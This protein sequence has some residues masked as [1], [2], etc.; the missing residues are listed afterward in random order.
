MRIK[1]VSFIGSKQ[2]GYEC[3]EK[4]YMLDKESLG[5]VITI[6]D[7]GDRRSYFNDIKQ[8]CKKLSIPCFVAENRDHFKGLIKELKPELGFVVG[9]YWLIDKETIDN[10]PNGF[11]GIHNSLL[12]KYRGGA[13]LVWSIINGDQQ[14]GFSFFSITE[15]MDDGDI[16]FQNFVDIRPNDYISD[17][18]RRI[19]HLT[20]MSLDNIYHKIL[21]REF[22]PRLQTGYG[23][24]YC[25]QRMLEDGKIDWNKSSEEIY[26]F[27][28]AQSTPYPGAFSMLH[29]D[30]LFILRATPLDILY[31]G[32]P[33]QVLK[34]TNSEVLV[35][36][37][38]NKAINI[39]QVRYN[40]VTTEARE[41][42]KS[43]KI[44][45]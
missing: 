10:V 12:P 18:L 9:W 37:G 16:W 6:D 28:R 4:I 23:I 38:D 21:S 22:F 36:C 34:I 3:L 41:V 25:G 45:F 32:T 11:I 8:F 40:E 1:N 33:G 42:I 26:N 44:R 35:I 43:I 39:Q 14:T 15:G 24:S 17:V 5:S 20:L 27:I 13:P 7:G 29:G 2:I 31:N 19:G 30:K